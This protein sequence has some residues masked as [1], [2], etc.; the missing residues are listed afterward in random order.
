MVDLGNPAMIQQLQS[1][2][3]ENPAALQPLVQAIAQSN[4]QLAT[5]L[6]ADPQGVLS[7]L[8]GMGGEGMAGLEGGEGEEELQLPTMDE[9]TPEDRTAVEQIEAMGIPQTKAIEAYLM[10]GRNVEMAVQYYFDNPGDF[11]D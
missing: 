6:N 2:I 3:R 9:L 5:A 11:A 4:P 7:L 8:A 1:L 10:C